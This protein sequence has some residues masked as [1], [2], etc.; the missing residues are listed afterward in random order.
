M[1]RSWGSMAWRLTHQSQPLPCSV[2]S[3]V[4]DGQLWDSG[5]GGGY[6]EEAA[7]G[8]DHEAGLVEACDARRGIARGAADEVHAEELHVCHGA[9]QW[10]ERA[11]LVW[12][13]LYMHSECRARWGEVE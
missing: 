3:V 5:G 13:D 8:A 9:E 6:V 11:H 4:T 12:R 1:V 2:Q 7:D 10:V